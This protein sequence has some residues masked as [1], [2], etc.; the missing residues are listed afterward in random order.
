MKLQS[1]LPIL[2]VP[3]FF[4]PVCAQGVPRP[5][6]DVLLKTASTALDNYQKLAPGIRCETANEKTLRD[7]CKVVLETLARDVDQARQRIAHYQ[8]LTSR[9]P[10]DLFDIYQDFDTIMGLIS[11]LGY[12]GELY[13]KN[14]SA[15]FSQAYN[16]FVKITL[17]LDGEVRKAMKLTNAAGSNCQ[18]S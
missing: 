18:Q 3:A 16:N 10:E 4:L 12:A 2:L 9:Q 7:S 13:G 8:S 17:W 14:N 15:L 1:V 11:Q 6:V 5:D